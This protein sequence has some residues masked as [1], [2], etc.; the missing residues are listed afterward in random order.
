MWAVAFTTAPATVILTCG[1]S[2]QSFNIGAGVNKLSIPLSPGKMTVQMIRSGQTII[3]YTPSDY[4]YVTNPVKCK[5]FLNI[6]RHTNGLI[7]DFQTI[8]MLGLVLQ[9][10][11]VFLLL[12]FLVPDCFRSCHHHE[13]H[14]HYEYHNNNN[15]IQR[16]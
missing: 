9:V 10:R 15:N 13:Y 5:Q 8:T 2:S 14:N 11:F 12:G 4:T 6:S 16:I 1:G 3:N 7:D